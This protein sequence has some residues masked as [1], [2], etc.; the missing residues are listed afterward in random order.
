MPSN[1]EPHR[2]RRHSDRDQRQPQRFVRRLA[3]IVGALD[4]VE[5]QPVNK[6]E[7]DEVLGVHPGRRAGDRAHRRHNDDRQRQQRGRHHQC[8]AWARPVGEQHDHR[9]RAEQCGDEPGQRTSGPGRAIRSRIQ[10]RLRRLCSG[11]VHDRPV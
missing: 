1:T 9:Q 2:R 6:A 8:A 7:R 5:Q 10:I 4:Q 3:Q 11:Y